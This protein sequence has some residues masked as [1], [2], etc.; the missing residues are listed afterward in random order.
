MIKQLVGPSPPPTPCLGNCRSVP[1]GNNLVLTCPDFMNSDVVELFYSES[2]FVIILVFYL[3]H[4][5][6]TTRS[7]PRNFGN[8]SLSSDLSYP[9]FSKSPLV[10]KFLAFHSCSSTS[11]VTYNVRD[12]EIMICAIIGFITSLSST[13]VGM[14]S[15]LAKEIAPLMELKKQ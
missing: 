14:L 4:A 6:F 3:V 13:L 10:H 12:Y 9:S 2:L 5:R 15:H 7:S 11:H 1:L 8:S